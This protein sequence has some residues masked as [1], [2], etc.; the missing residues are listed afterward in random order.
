VQLA[1]ERALADTQAS[2]QFGAAAFVVAFGGPQRGQ[3]GAAKLM[4]LAIMNAIRGENEAARAEARRD[5][6]RA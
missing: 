1:T 3:F 2:C 6:G 4:L 5:E